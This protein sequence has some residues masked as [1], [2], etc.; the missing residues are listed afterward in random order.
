VIPKT[1]PNI[2]PQALKRRSA[3]QIRIYSISW[4]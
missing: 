4:V 2:K 3:F 1:S